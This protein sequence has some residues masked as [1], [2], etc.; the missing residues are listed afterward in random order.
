MPNYI[1]LS[2]TSLPNAP[3]TSSVLLG[4]NTNNDLIL[5]DYYGNTNFS[6]NA[7]NNKLCYVAKLTQTG[8]NPPTVTTTT[9]NT[10]GFT[11]T[12]YRVNSGQYWFNFSQ[13]VD[14][15]KIAP[16]LPADSTT[17]ALLSTIELNKHDFNPNNFIDLSFDPN[18]SADGFNDVVISTA[19]Q[20][21]GKILCGGV[22]S[23]F[24]GSNIA[25]FIARLNSDG[26]LDTTFNTNA[27]TGF[28]DATRALVLQPDEKILVG[29]Y[30]TQYNGFVTPTSITRLNSDGT[31]DGTFN[32]N[33]G[34][35]TGDQLVNAIALQPDGKILV[36]GTFTIFN[37]S[38][39]NY[40][41]RL[42]SDG[43]LDTTFNISGSGFIGSPGMQINTIALQPDGKILCGGNFSGYVDQYATHSMSHIARLNSNGT[44]D[45]TFN[46]NG[47]GFIGGTS[48]NTIALQ[49]DGKIICGGDFSEYSDQ[50]DAYRIQYI[51][52]LTSNGTFDLSFINNNYGA[53]YIVRTIAIQPGADTVMVGGEFDSYTDKNGTSYSCNSIIRLDKDGLVLNNFSGAGFTN[54]PVHTISVLDY[55]KVI[56]GGDFTQYNYNTYGQKISKLITA[57]DIYL[58]SRD[59]FKVSNDGKLLNTPIEIRQ[60]I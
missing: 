35:G 37:G 41:A 20:S 59:Y 19:I 4:V 55:Q 45:T 26:T 42:N 14:Y 32:I 33:A 3:N 50:Y 12:W 7:S 17:S 1:E 28:N 10:F 2:Q 36:G 24:Y 23:I 29:G 38:T 46:I 25:N 21:D 31:L 11:P 40:I 18:N 58:T 48:V 53:N 56:V 8:G 5:K 43:T 44:F 51:C 52:R 39:T 47:S 57:F 15:N 54:S 9:L 27:G 30:F 6:V 22:F 34:S 13:S 49:S 16:F 60:Y